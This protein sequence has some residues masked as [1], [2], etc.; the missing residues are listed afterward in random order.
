MSSLPRA[1]REPPVLPPPPLQKM[2]SEAQGADEL[3]RLL[4]RPRPQPGA[5]TDVSW[6]LLQDTGVP[7]RMLPWGAGRAGLSSWSLG[8]PGEG[9][10]WI[11]WLLVSGSISSGLV[12][13]VE[14]SGRPSRHM[15]VRLRQ[16][17]GAGGRAG[18]NPRHPEPHRPITGLV[19]RLPARLPRGP[20]PDPPHHKHSLL[21]GG[22][23]QTHQ[24]R[25]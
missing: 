7:I 17:W 22:A 18:E 13:G 9:A 10:G 2:M 4:T 24:P 15:L 5:D 23:W 3:T 8:S 20:C 19:P 25:A 6:H 21:G 14:A 16:S 1:S 11:L 12:P